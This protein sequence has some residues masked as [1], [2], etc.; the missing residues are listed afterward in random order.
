MIRDKS[1]YKTLLALSIPA[2]FQ[3]LMNL[4]VV[5]ADNLMV[6]R[7]DPKGV[8]FAAVSQSNAISNLVLAL[9]TGLASGA[10]V[11]VSQYWGKEDTT[12]LRSIGAAALWISL[13]FCLAIIV[14]L[15]LFPAQILMLVIRSSEK[16]VMTQA[17]QYLPIVVFSYLPYAVTA[18]LIG[19]LKGIQIVRIT[20]YTTVLAL[21]SNVGLNYLLIFG[22]LGFPALGVRGAA[23]ATVISRLLETLAVVFFALKRQTKLPLKPKDFKLPLP[24]AFHD[25]ARYA[26]PVGLTDA[27]WALV[28]MLKMV[29]IGQMG[30]LMINA[31][32]M[33]DMMMIL[34]TV[35]TQALA[36][37]ACV[38]VG[39]AVGAGD[40][41]LVKAYS[42]TIQRLFLM[43]GLVMSALVFALRIPFVSLYGQS[44]EATSLAIQMIGLCAFTLIGTTYHAS[45]F[46]GINRGAG[47][48]RFVMLVDMIC[49]WLVVLPLASLSAFVFRLPMA[50]V[51]FMTR[52]DQTFKWIIAYKRLKGDKWIHRI[53]R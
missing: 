13:G 41:P 29:I 25:F 5:M 1:F 38:L 26:L 40:I 45:C 15:L 36:G 53:T 6:A 12:K 48:N 17:L 50:V 31:V 4:L 33:A 10:V 43:I 28:G 18:A 51:Y 49:G 34:G 21:V 3:S 9:L 24:W 30:K 11:L 44:P 46:V 7:I 19:L 35:F 52:V 20:L 8:A 32:A 22:H 37:G 27:Q 2:A 47:D 14:L 39:K 23:I 16:E 42:A